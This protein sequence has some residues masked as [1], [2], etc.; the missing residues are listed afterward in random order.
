M[1]DRAVQPPTSSVAAIGWGFYLACSWTWVIG[2]Y[3]PVLLIRDFGWAGWLAFAVPNVLGAAAMG[4]ILRSPAAAMRLAGDHPQAVR[5]FSTVTVSFQVFALLWLLPQL[6]GLSGIALVLAALLCATLLPLAAG[7]ALPMNA[8]V[9][10]LISAA[11]FLMLI[12]SE[13]LIFPPKEGSEPAWHLLGLIPVCVFGFLLCPYLDATFL[14]ARANTDAR[15]A[16]IAFSV[17]FG[18]LFLVMILFTMCYAIGLDARV[19]T[20]LGAWLIATHLA[21]QVCFTLSAHT[22]VTRNICGNAIG[23]VVAAALGMAA[24]SSDLAEAAPFGMSGGE[25]IYRGFMGFYAL[26]FPAYVLLVV[27]GGASMRRYWIACVL[28][29]PL[30][31]AAFVYGWMPAAAGGVLIVLVTWLMPQST[32]SSRLEPS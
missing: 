25:L 8:V 9:V 16:R 26:F 27:V 1:T 3:L 24:L 31:A 10:W 19:F 23:M 15:G 22:A 13:A 11:V 21:V 32:G 6:V 20:G 5:L 30:L 18:V 2:M 17:G 28:A 12:P 14:H 29:L 7:L 4:W